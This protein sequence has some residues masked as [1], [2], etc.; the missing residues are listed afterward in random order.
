MLASYLKLGLGD[1]LRAGF[2]AEIA[3]INARGGG[4]QKVDLIFVS[5]AEGTK[6]QILIAF[7]SI[8]R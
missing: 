7:I 3:D 4:D 2:N 6:A 8:V 1:E 5:S